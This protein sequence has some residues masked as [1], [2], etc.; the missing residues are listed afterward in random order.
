[1]KIKL[2]LLG[3]TVQISLKVF[4]AVF[5]FSFFI[6]LTFWSFYIYVNII[7]ERNILYKYSQ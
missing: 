5:N 6:F 1:M 2:G 7:F 4:Y 3:N